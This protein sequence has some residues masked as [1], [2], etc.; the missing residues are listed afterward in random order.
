MGFGDRANDPY[1]LRDPYEA[2]EPGQAGQAGRIRGRAGKVSFAAGGASPVGSG[3]M[4]YGAAQNAFGNKH[5]AI[6]LAVAL[7]LVLAALLCTWN[8]VRGPSIGAYA[9]EEIRIIGLADEDFAVTPAELAELKCSQLTVEG[10][11]KGQGGESKAGTVTAYGPTLAR[12][13]EKYGFEPTDFAR[14]V[15]TCSDGYKVTLLGDMLNQTV[16]LSIAQGKSSLDEGH[17]P[18]RLVMPSAES[19]KWCYGI[20]SMEFQR[21]ADEA[22]DEEGEGADEGFEGA[23]GDAA[24]ADEMSGSGD[25]DGS[26]SAE[27]SGSGASASSEY[28]SGGS[29]SSSGLKSFGQS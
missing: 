16:I 14:I 4:G 6:S 21:L 10:Q 8:V 2:P 1:A 15:V 27:A 22:F 23:E 5:L 28:A 29:S 9:D 13:V 20:E 7:A 19:G 12:F 18:M 26:A 3:G 25:A 24:F 11:G 17:Q